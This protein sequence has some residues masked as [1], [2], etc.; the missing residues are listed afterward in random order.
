MK[1]IE[2][3]GHTDT[4][5]RIVVTVTVRNNRITIPAKVM[6]VLDVTVGDVLEFRV[7][8]CGV[9]MKKYQGRRESIE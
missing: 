4:L 9:E 6:R 5:P 3:K 1:G 2:I 8:E 7:I